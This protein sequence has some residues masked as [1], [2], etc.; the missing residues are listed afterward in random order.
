MTKAPLGGALSC[1]AL[2]LADL[3][4]V[5]ALRTFCDF[6]AERVTFAERVKR[7]S[8]QLV[9]VEEEILCLA[10][11]LDEAEALVGETSDSSC[12]H[13]AFWKL[14]KYQVQLLEL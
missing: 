10:F 11:D 3:D 5:R 8:L 13:D 4:R 7:N 14:V 9:R 1:E 6:E 12:L 2:G